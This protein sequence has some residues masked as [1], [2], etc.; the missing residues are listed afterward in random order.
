[1]AHQEQVEVQTAVEDEPPRPRVI[2]ADAD[3]LAR[4]VVRDVLQSTKQFVVA[5]EA[6]D[7]IEAVELAVYYRPE[8][9]LMEPAL[10]RLDG[11]AATR[12][13]IEKAPEVRIIMFS[14]ACE[15]DL[16]LRA[17]RAGAS[18]FISKEVE[19]EAVAQAMRAVVRGEAAISRSLTMSLIE[20]LRAIPEPGKGM[21]PVRSVLTT[22]EWEVLDLMSGGSST[23]DIA[24]VLVLA[25]DTVYSHVKNIM[26]KLHVHTRAEAVE[27]AGRLCRDGG[28]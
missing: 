25:E 15:G 27:E 14:V 7:G 21:R 13:I 2:I 20:H 4:R 6:G 12:R 5:A 9:M 22:R 1:M 11:V 3:P 18:G 26:R 10:P 8:L 17:L 19:I 23:A 24:D 16:E 28:A